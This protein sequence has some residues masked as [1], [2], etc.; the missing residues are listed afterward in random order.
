[1]RSG[2][3]LCCTEDVEVCGG[4]DVAFVGREGEDGDG[5]LGQSTEALALV[6]WREGGLGHYRKAVTL[7]MNFVCQFDMG[8]SPETKQTDVC[9]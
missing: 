6:M 9:K 7:V 1:M 3:G 8:W 5:N 2:R 4:S